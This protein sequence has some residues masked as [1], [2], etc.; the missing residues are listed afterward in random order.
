[1][2]ICKEG[3]ARALESFFEE[4]PPRK[5]VR[6]YLGAGCGGSRLSLALDE[7][8]KDD[9]TFQSGGFSFCINDGLLGLVKSVTLDCNDDGFV[10]EPELP[11]PS[12]GGDA[13]ACSCSGGCHG[14]CGH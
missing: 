3:A 10:V 12:I 1:M 9:S 7:P 4:N 2:I 5:T 8:G 11:L 14:C 6:I 13:G